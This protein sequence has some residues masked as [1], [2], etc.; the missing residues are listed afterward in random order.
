MRVSELGT[1]AQKADLVAALAR[2]ERSNEGGGLA[3]ELSAKDHF[4][5]V[6]FAGSG[7]SVVASTLRPLQAR[8]HMLR[9]FSLQVPGRA[10]HS[11]TELRQMVDA[12]ERGDG[13]A[14]RML[15][16]LHVRNAGAAA[17]AR[18]VQYAD[19]QKQIP[20]KK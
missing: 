20:A 14:A 16:A 17:L 9:G 7:N 10:D 18:L 13:D 15:G 5:D 12:I 6:L 11:L 19:E 3:A 8:A 4:Y 2:I 1:P